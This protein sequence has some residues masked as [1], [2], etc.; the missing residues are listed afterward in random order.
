MRVLLIRTTPAGLWKRGFLPPPV[1]HPLGLMTLQAV[2]RAD[3][4]ADDVRIVDPA[5]DLADGAEL[6]RLVAELAPTVVGFS[7]LIVEAP[8][9]R[10]YAGAARQA[11]PGA[12]L[13]VGG[14]LASSDVT[15]ALADPALDYAVLGEGEETMVELCRAFDRG[16]DTRGIRGL[17]MR[18]PDGAVR[19][20]PPRPPLE[21]LDELPLL[22]WDG[23][24]LAAYGKVFNMNDLP[25]AD[26]RYASLMTTRGC[27]YRCSYCHDIFGRRTRALSMDRLMEE[28]AVL[29]H[30][31]DVR[32]FHFVDDLF[33][34][35]K[36]RIE[37]FCRT[38]ADRGWSIRY[39]FPNGLRG[40]RLTGDELRSLRS[41]GC[42]ALSIAVESTSDRLQRLVGKRLDV[43]RTLEQVALAADL[44]MVTRAFVMIG[45]PGETEQ[46]MVATIETVSESAFDMI[47]VFT[48]TPHPGTELHRQVLERGHELPPLGGESFDYDRGLINVSA[49]S[50][51][52]FREIVHW[53]RH[54]PYEVERRKRRLRG[55]FREYGI[56]RYAVADSSTW[57]LVHR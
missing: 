11:A 1:A 3:G 15:G 38:V 6:G 21:S 32:D 41:T 39:A 29:I 57:E 49:V 18:G 43:R 17:A 27:P 16:G 30:R 28:M 46:E 31:H 10:E 26:D 5:V 45:F 14:P 13:V 4:V 37:A 19:V 36:G 20:E 2:L 54:M 35:E 55:V 51:E 50:D 24:R 9:L 56:D 47:N 42:Y 12:A 40:D 53:A 8:L 25:V 44:G 22:D 23:V 48:V 33:N 52:R 34:F 7:S